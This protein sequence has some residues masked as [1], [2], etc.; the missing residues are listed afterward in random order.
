MLMKIQLICGFLGAGKTTLLKNLLEHH[1]SDTAVLVNEFGEL[2]IDGALVSEGTNLNVVEMPS[3]CICCSLRESLV[4]AVQEIMENFKPTQLI[5]EPSGIASPSSVLLGLTKADYS[6][7]IKIEPVIG[8]VDLT[9]YSG[10]VDAD[11]LGNFFKD[12][13]MNSD[14]ILLNKADLVSPEEMEKSRNKVAALNPSAL[15]IPTVYCQTELPET[16]AKG[17]ITHFHFSP[18]FHA[19]SFTFDGTVERAKVQDLLESLK[20]GEYGSIY[21]AK[22][23][24][25][26]EKGPETFDYVNGQVNF[27]Q[28]G[29]AEKN[30]LVFIG[31]EVNRSK[32]EKAVRN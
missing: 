5:I 14:I 24:V 32:I 20:D 21:R 17:E 13:I 15:I 1:G 11:D 29:S 30:K 31:R 25:R 6:D 3:G 16:S 4:D 19:E 23:I 28:I 27:S 26:T 18:H 2:G 10:D 12:Q 8:I 22:G 9:F 7:L